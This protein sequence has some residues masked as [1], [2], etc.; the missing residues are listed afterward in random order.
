MTPAA[1]ANHL[2][3]STVFIGVCWIATLLLKTNSARVRHW[4]WLAA[5]LKLL[6]P[7]S[8]FVGLGM[9]VGART[10][11]GLP[12]PS[13]P[14]IRTVSQPFSASEPT[15]AELTP[16][17]VVQPSS[18]PLTRRLFLLLW[19]LG[20]LS[21]AF[22]RIWGWRRTAILTR[23][24]RRLHEGREVELL[25]RVQ[26][27]HG[28]TSRLRLAAAASTV[29]PGVHGVLRP[30]LLLPAGITDQLDDDH[31]ETI[32]AHE[33]C[34][35]GRRDNLLATLH[36]IVETIFW[37][38]PLVWWIGSRLVD[39]RERACDE[40]VLRM[41]NDPLIYAG[42]ILQV[43]EFYL[44]TPDSV[45]SRATG[46]NLKIRIE[47]IMTQRIIH[48]VGVA[49][50]LL[51]AGVAIAFVAVPVAFGM[52]RAQRTSQIDEVLE[53]AF[54]ISPLPQLQAG[55]TARV[56]QALPPVKGPAPRVNTTRPEDPGRAVE[57]YLARSTVQAAPT[58]AR[59][60]VPKEYV[61]GPEDELEIVVWR[62]PELSR[63]RVVVRPDGRIGLPLLS[64]IPAAGL[65]PM[66]LRDSI[67][68]Q[69][70]NWV[71]DPHVTVLVQT[72]TKP[73]VTIQGAIAKPGQYSLASRT[74]VLALIG[75]AGGFGE[76]AQRNQIVVFREENGKVSRHL[77]NYATFVS[78]SD[79]EQNLI[80][81]D[82]DIVI[83]Q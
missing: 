69:L 61:I 62:Q 81:Q 33:L 76:F 31:L 38:Y 77:F 65:T 27:R 40:D 3:Q 46:S 14:A 28:L 39:E 16:V 57:A 60:E 25:R 26:S 37:F 15:S 66:A 74:T 41:G 12:Q 75:R 5:S 7:V 2:W 82:G 73:Q 47:D 8:L 52:S 10:D 42:A 70:K 58:P 32:L 79:L 72:P 54:P 78:G 43:C 29:E 23:G 71:D 51:L 20:C 36:V 24:A 13:W 17:H 45:V 49:R 35:I 83:V 55:A 21:V 34:H 11:I 56:S 19:L 30:V 80:L 44:A 9:H 50:T 68:S 64:D 53:A 1:V 48:K 6:L 59:Q 63:A 18:T 67:Q 22:F 4:I